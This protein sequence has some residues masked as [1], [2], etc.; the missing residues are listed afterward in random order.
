MENF[1]TSD[2]QKT[3]YVWV[4]AKDIYANFNANMVGS[5]VSS[6]NKEDNL[7]FLPNS[8]FSGYISPFQ[9]NLL[10]GYKAEYNLELI[11]KQ[12]F[13]EYPSRLVAT[14]LFESEKDAMRYKE[15]H[16]FHVGNRQL[17][18]GK[19]VSHYAYS[20]H[21]LAWIDFLRSPLLLEEEKTKEIVHKYW[22]GESV[23]NYKLSVLENS[24]AVVGQSVF[25]VLFIGRIDFEK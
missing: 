4:E 7:M 19:T 25:E 24:L 20:K 5:F 12:Y 9:S 21:D 23:E 18:V 2:V 10:R 15:S 3:F 11:R 13:A 6:N 22:K 1:V 17:K 14:F 16:S 8:N